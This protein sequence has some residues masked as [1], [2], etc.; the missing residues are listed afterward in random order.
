M[1]TASSCTTRTSSRARC[2]VSA[3]AGR[4]ATGCASTSPVNIAATRCSSAQDSYSGVGIVP[5]GTNE[6]HGRHP[7]LDGS[8]Q[9]LHRHGQLVRLHAVHRRRH[10]LCHAHRRRHEGRQRA[11]HDSV[12]YGTTNT[13]TNFAYAFYAGVSFDVTPQVGAS[14]SPTATPTSARRRAAV[15]TTYRRRSFQ[16]R[17]LHSRHHLQRCDA[18][19]A[20][21]VPARSRRLSAGEVTG[22]RRLGASSRNFAGP[23]AGPAF[24]PRRRSR[25]P[26]VQ[27]RF[28]SLL[29]REASAPVGRL[30][31]SRAELGRRA[32]SRPA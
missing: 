22:R 27:V 19:H 31:P 5:A 16:Q 12:A 14:T 6:Y 8:R 25:L 4:P 17:R 20:L 24:R 28:P 9:R 21:Q 15:V 2:S 18:R 26:E 32:G 23:P 29:T 10:R 11:R 7:Q 1:P 13:N 30:Q 3:S